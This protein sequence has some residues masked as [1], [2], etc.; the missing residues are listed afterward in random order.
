MGYH[1]VAN[2][3]LISVASNSNGLLAAHTTCPQKVKGETLLLVVLQGIQADI[4]WA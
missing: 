3:P 1:G 2:N 4:T